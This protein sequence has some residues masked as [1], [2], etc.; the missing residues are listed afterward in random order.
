MTDRK[1]FDERGHD[2]DTL[3]L[4]RP[5]RGRAPPN[6][7]SEG[8]AVTASV[9]VNAAAAPIVH[10]SIIMLFLERLGMMVGEGVGVHA[11]VCMY[12]TAFNVL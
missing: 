11:D 4:S 10:W 5:R 12:L 9:R 7:P 2:S 1:S 3:A 8:F 6:V